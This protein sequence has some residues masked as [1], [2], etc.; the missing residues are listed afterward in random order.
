M[1]DTQANAVIEAYKKL[2]L[3]LT[4][5]GSGEWPVLVLSR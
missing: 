1:L 5:R 4:D 2:G 3:A